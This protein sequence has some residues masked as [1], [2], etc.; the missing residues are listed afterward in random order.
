[1]TDSLRREE[2]EMNRQT[3]GDDERPLSYGVDLDG[4]RLPDL[5]TSTGREV[6]IYSGVKPGV[7]GKNLTL[8]SSDPVW[9]AARRQSSSKTPEQVS[10]RAH[11]LKCFFKVRAPNSPIPIS[12]ETR[13]Y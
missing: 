7:K 13:C 4:D 12:R 3:I 1:M 11:R 6:R 9:R 2:E 5:V 10:C 8:V